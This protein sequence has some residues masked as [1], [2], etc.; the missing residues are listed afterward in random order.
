MSSRP[1][2]ASST[3]TK[4]TRSPASPTIPPSHATCPARA[5]NRRCLRLWKALLPRCL[6]RAA[7][8]ILSRSSCRST[9]PTSCSCVA[10]PSPAWRKSSPPEAAP[11]PSA[12]A[13]RW[14]RRE[15]QGGGG[16]S[17][18]RGRAGEVFREVE[19]GD[20]LKYG[21]IPEFVG[22]LPVLATLEDLDEPTLKRI[23]VEP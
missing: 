8:N 4:S 20:L 9:P 2:A 13:P 16:G 5:C 23:L 10:A 11:P 1:S 17:R 7:A 18:G 21:L 19:P 14:R 22:R 3:S 12:S 6:R 15:P